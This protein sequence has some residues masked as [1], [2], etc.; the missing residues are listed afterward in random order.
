[1]KD[2]VSNLEK[3]KLKGSPFEGYLI[4]PVQRVPKYVLLLK[5]LLKNTSN[6]HCDYDNISKALE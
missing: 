5:D 6:I 4:K 1:M 2:F 3:T